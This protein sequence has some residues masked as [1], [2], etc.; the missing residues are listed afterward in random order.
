MSLRATAGRL[1]LAGAALAAFT[2]IAPGLPSAAAATTTLTASPSAAKPGVVVTVTGK[3]PAQA[4]KPYSVAQIYTNN[5]VARA[6]QNEPSAGVV[7]ADGS[8]HATVTVPT[9]ATRSDILR[10]YG[11]WQYDE[12]IFSFP[13]TNCPQVCTTYGVNV[14][15]LPIS[16]NQH[17]TLGTLA[18]R[19]G[20][21]LS[22]RTTSCVGGIA[23]EFARV[24]DGNGAYFPLS[25]TLS[26]TTFTGS[27]D[28]SKGFRG[29][30]SPTGAAH[31]SSP[32]GTK[33]S[34][35]AVPCLQSE[36]P[37]S[38]AAADN[39][40]HLTMVI[41][42]TICPATGACRVSSAV[43]PAGQVPVFGAPSLSTST[44]ALPEAQ[45]ASAIPAQ[46][47]FVG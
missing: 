20:S 32:I 25:G 30:D 38:V 2:A 7:G 45:A 4:G 16:T 24:I 31:V 46:P 11:S 23:T 35:V 47:N 33:D 44:A 28:L 12:I 19:T 21:K 37:P 41:D 36:G 42:I 43:A 14:T 40:D 10:P 1:L 15:V 27:A 5:H 17:I 18:P 22:V 8:V 26:G 34:F 6:E 9:G 13:A 29:K 3:I 39:L